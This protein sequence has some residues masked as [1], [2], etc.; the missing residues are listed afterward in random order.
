[1]LFVDLLFC[2]FVGRR[3]PKIE[4]YPEP[5]MSVQRGGSV[6]FQCRV[7]AGDPPPKVVWTRS[8]Y[9]PI[10]RQKAAMAL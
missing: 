5:E 8:V 3:R 4:V 10:T 2:V 7:M 9:S 6:L 1:M